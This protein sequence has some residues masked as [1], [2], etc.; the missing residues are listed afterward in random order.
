[1]DMVSFVKKITAGVKAQLQI[2]IQEDAIYISSSKRTNEV[3]VRHA[4]ESG[5]ES[6]LIEALK[7]FKSTKYHATVVLCSRYYQSYQIDKPEIPKSEWSTALPFLLKDLITERPTDIVADAC[8]LPDGKRI[9]AYVLLLSKL[10]TLTKILSEANI[11]LQRVLPEEEVWG[12]VQSTQQNFMLLYNSGRS[13]YKV[14]AFVNTKSRLQRSI[15]GIVPPLTGVA[16]SE[17]QLD[18]VALELQRSIDYLSS[19]MRDAVINHLFICSDGDDNEQLASALSE[20][21]NLKVAPLDS[22]QK[23]TSGHILCHFTAKLSDEGVNLHPAHLR[24]KKREIT[25]GVVVALWGALFITMMGGYVY[26]KMENNQIKAELESRKKA[27]E[28]VG[29]RRDN[30]EKALAARKASQSKMYDAAKVAADV[31][32]KRATLAAIN[33]FDGSLKEGYSGVMG[34]LAAL[35]QQDISISSIE[36]NEKALNLK[37]IARTPGSVPKWIKRFKTEF[38]LLNRTFEKMEIGRNEDGVVT[39]ELVTEMNSSDTVSEGAK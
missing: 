26:L 4:I 27:T 22:E 2:V 39:F 6:G 37:G 31:E 18:N 8:L 9:Q 16:S 10:K 17:M 30:L 24:V 33:Q 12:L 32:E 28:S 21:L 19:Q 3:P 1:M 25:L 20:R 14:G 38:A 29:E 35:A 34:S 23:R 7:T 5:W 15:R 13:S 11:T 36:M